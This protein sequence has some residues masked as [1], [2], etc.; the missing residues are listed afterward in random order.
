MKRKIYKDLLDWKNA[1]SFREALL[2]DGARRVGKSY[3]VEEFA[4]SEYKSYILVNFAQMTD[5]VREIFN[6]YLATPDDFFTRLQLWSGKRLYERESLIIFDEVQRYPKAREAIKW[7]VADGRYSYIETGSLV[8]IRK[9]VEGITLP[10]EEAHIDMFPMDFEEFLWAMGEEMLMPYIRER[11]HDLKPMG[12]AL[13]RKAMD[14]LRLYMIIGGMPQAI[15]AYIDTKDFTEVDRVKRNILNLYRNDIYQYAGD[16]APKVVQI[17][18]SIPSQL[19]RREK[20]FRIGKVKKG[21]RTR[22]FANAFFWLDESRVVNICYAATEPTIGLKLHRDDSRYKLYFGDTG[23]LISHSFDEAEIQSDEL[24]RKLMLGKLEIN[25]G[26]FVE[27]IVAQMFRANRKQLYYY[28]N[29]DHTNFENNMEIDFLI[30][31]PI[32]TSRHN[33]CPVE[34]KSTQRYTTSSLDKFR[35]KYGNYLHTSYILHSSDVRVTN[36]V[37]Y[38]PL[39]MA[40][41][42]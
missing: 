32:I 18:D 5:E 36:E 34:V 9:S 15:Q 42:L 13:H 38:L 14:Y 4:K 37:T 29:V 27:N 3:I 40:A 2:I 19:Q 12:A 28:S 23:L 10:S 21:A 16:D 17:F 22:E 26:M 41:T 39:Y 1:R 30:R 31:K 35:K 20:R 24:Y 25:K 8:S 6:N 7:L 33:I 11:A